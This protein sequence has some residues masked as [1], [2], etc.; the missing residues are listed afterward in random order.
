MAHSWTSQYK[1]TIIFHFQF[2]NRLIHYRSSLIATVI[3]KCGH[4]FIKLRCRLQLK[5]D[6]YSKFTNIKHDS[7]SKLQFITECSNGSILN[8]TSAVLR[9]VSFLL[10]P[11]QGLL[12]FILNGDWGEDCCWVYWLMAGIA[13]TALLLWNFHAQLLFKPTC[14]NVIMTLIMHFHLHLHSMWSSRVPHH[15]G[16]GHTSS[17]VCVCTCSFV[18]SITI[19]FSGW[20]AKMH[21][22]QVQMKHEKHD[23]LRAHF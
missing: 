7:E 2:A 3:V 1:K 15:L 19:W 23:C 6:S 18:W 21:Y 17:S 11:I 13:S 16:S 14:C 20:S 8:K 12:T 5:G 9:C 10:F 22:C 4:G